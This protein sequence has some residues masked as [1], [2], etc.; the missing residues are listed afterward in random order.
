LMAKQ[1]ARVS[2]SI[3]PMVLFMM[4]SGKPINNTVKELKLGMMAKAFTKEDLSKVKRLVRL[5]MNQMET[6]MKETS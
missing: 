4:V 3:R 2:L 6:Y 1:K 5:A